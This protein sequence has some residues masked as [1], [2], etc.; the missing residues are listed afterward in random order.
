MLDNADGTSPITSPTK[1]PEYR[2][3]DSRIKSGVAENI[4]SVVVVVDTTRTAGATFGQLAD[5]VAMVSLARID[6]DADFADSPTILRLFA[7]PSLERVS[8][9]LTTWDQ[10]FLKALYRTYDPLLHPRG[11]IATNMAQDLAP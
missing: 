7:E 4:F 1:S 5:Y 10:A 11:V 6:P 2:L 3:R 8:T 9:R